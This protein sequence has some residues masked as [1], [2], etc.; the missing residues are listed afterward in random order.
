MVT[1]FF[2]LHPEAVY[3]FSQCGGGTNDPHFFPPRQKDDY[4]LVS[5]PGSDDSLDSLLKKHMVMIEYALFV[6]LRKKNPIVPVS[7]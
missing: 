3:P 6:S 2:C 7:K 1:P 4:F 5:Y